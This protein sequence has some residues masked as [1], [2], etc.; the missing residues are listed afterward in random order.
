M[1]LKFSRQNFENYS[2]T[3]FHRNLYS[4]I[5]TVPCRQTDRQHEAGSMLPKGPNI[6]LYLL[7]VSTYRL[8]LRTGCFYVPA[9]PTYRLFLR[10]GCFYV[11]AV[12]TCRLFLRTGCFYVP[13]VPTYQL[14][15]TGTVCTPGGSTAVSSH[16]QRRF[17]H[18]ELSAISDQ[19]ADISA[20]TLQSGTVT[21][22][23]PFQNNST[24]RSN[25]PYSMVQ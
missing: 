10:T 17:V 18:L 22:V 20:C 15:P 1:R 19:S 9:V 23:I 24:H 11:P 2:N 3:K 7:A 12:S 21:F 14:F 16:N 4:L 25:T 5:R 13:T 6:L 8:F